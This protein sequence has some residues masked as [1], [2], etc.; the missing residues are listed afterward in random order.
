MKAL[1]AALVLASL[2]VAFGEDRRIEYS[3]TEKVCTIS[4]EDFEFMLTWKSE[5][6][7]IIIKQNYIIKAQRELLRKYLKET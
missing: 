4:K 3:C 2:P 7:Q 6:E 5:A 1:I